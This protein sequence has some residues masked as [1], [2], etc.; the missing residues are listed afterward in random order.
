MDAIVRNITSLTS[1]SEDDL[2]HIIEQTWH[3]LDGKVF[4]AQIRE[5]AYKVAAGF[6]SA[7]V[8]AYISLFVRRQT[9]ELLR[10]K[11]KIEGS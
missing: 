4:L 10:E 11:T 3:D 5:T 1:I 7:A 8:T 9:R 6:H 2:S